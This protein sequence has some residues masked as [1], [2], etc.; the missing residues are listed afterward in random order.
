MIV[1]INGV[2]WEIMWVKKGSKKLFCDDTQCLGVTYFDKKRIYLDRGLSEKVFE[3][4]TVHELTHAFLYGYG[5][6]LNE[7]NNIEETIC[8]FIGMHIKKIL[9]LTSKIVKVWKVEMMVKAFY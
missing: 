5:V 7:E 3:E 1:K 2:K 4:T 9:K 6:E 8:D